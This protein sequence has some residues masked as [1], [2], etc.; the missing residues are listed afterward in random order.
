MTA[1]NA[2]NSTDASSEHHE[3]FVPTNSTLSA[4]SAT[5]SKL[6]EYLNHTHYSSTE[7]SKASEY[8][9]KQICVSE[10]FELRAPENSILTIEN[11]FYG[12]TSTSICEPIK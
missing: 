2:V 7:D 12:V 8:L 10:N 9:N 11:S 6:F 1:T 5:Q 4:S 3:S